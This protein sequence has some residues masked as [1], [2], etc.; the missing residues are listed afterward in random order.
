MV[1]TTALRFEVGDP[2][3]GTVDNY[4]DRARALQRAYEHQQEHAR[5]NCP[6]PVTVFDRMAHRGDTCLWGSDGR[7]I[8]KKG[9]LHVNPP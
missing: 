2:I 6:D 3:C 5:E 7:G 9:A 8:E 4:P 1:R